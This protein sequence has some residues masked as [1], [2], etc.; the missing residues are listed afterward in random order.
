MSTL[1]WINRE[2]LREKTREER[3]AEGEEEL[4]Q[5]GEYVEGGK[6]I[7]VPAPENLL[8]KVWDNITRSWREGRGE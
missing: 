8:K 7:T 4:L 3:I 2:K 5:D 6:I 1:V